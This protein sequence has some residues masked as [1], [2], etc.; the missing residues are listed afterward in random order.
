MDLQEYLYFS[1]MDRDI[2]VID[3]ESDEEFN[4]TENPP[5]AEKTH[6]KDST[7]RRTVTVKPKKRSR[8]DQ[9]TD[10]PVFSMKKPK[11]WREVPLPGKIRG[12]VHSGT[13]SPHKVELVQKIL[14]ADMTCGTTTESNDLIALLKLF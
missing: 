11:V 10:A 8:W 2:L 9:I 1:G 6:C 7:E 12:L 5:S 13:L 14:F 4:P 3:A